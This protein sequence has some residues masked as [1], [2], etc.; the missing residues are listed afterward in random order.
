MVALLANNVALVPAHILAD[1]TAI[2][3]FGMA[4]TVK[5]ARL[6]QVPLAP[7]TVPVATGAPLE[8]PIIVAPLM[9]FVVKPTIGP[10]V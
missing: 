6:V 9:V 4:F 5:V 3:G 1:V 7:I 8:V 10:Q 2:V